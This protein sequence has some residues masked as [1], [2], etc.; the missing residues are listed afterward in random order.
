MSALQATSASSVNLV[1][2]GPR[3]RTP[4]VLVHPVGLDLI[5]WGAQIDALCDDHDMVAYDLPGHGAS[6]GQPAD[7]TLD[8][9]AEVLAQVVRSTGGG[10]A[11]L[12]GLSVGGMSRRLSPHRSPTWCIR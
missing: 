2:T 12:V 10:G 9:A 4:V 11:H 5:Y 3:G 1:R 7:W 8:Q 6:A